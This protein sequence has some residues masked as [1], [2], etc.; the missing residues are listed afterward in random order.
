MRVGI[1]QLTEVTKADG[2]FAIGRDWQLG[3]FS[4]IARRHGE[5]A[6]EVREVRKCREGGQYF[7][8]FGETTLKAVGT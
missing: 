1:G 7:W 8:D 3:G 4:A 2:S 6:L 5:H